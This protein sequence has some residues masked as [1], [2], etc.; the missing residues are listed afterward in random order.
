M[1]SLAVPLLLSA[2]FGSVCAGQDNGSS[3]CNFDAVAHLRTDTGLVTLAAGA[4]LGGTSGSQT[5]YADAAEVIHEFFQAPARLILPI[6]ARV[7][8]TGTTTPLD[9]DDPGY[10]LDGDV[11]F[12][13]DSAGR[14]APGSLEI[15][16]LIVDLAVSVGAAIV[17]A[18]S[19]GAFARPS[20]RL[21]H[22]HGIVRLHFSTERSRDPHVPL[23]RAI[24]PA[25]RLDR[26]PKMEWLPQPAYPVGLM[27]ANMGDRV[28]LQFV[29]DARGQVDSTTL[30]IV[31]VAI[32]SSP[33]NPT[34]WFEARGSGPAGSGS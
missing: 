4:R 32:P 15:E 21:L 13:L 34:A 1:R 11:R 16:T 8:W 7:Y 3:R 30:S 24:V 25:L 6:W 19:A 23:L 33:T 14:V 18:D 29:V 2:V 26:V 31:R 12:Q 9:S 10:G 27:N 22:D 28:V 17:R 5:E 20:D